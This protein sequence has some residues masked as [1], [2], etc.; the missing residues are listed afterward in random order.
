MGLAGGLNLYGF[1]GGD[2]VNFSDPFGLCPENMGGDG[3]HNTLG[4]CPVGSKGAEEFNRRAGGAIEKAP[5]SPL[6]ALE[7][8]ATAGVSGE[9]RAAIGGIISGFTK[10]GINQAISR[11]GVGVSSKAIL[12]AVKN[13]V[14]TVLQSEGRRLF[15]GRDARVVVNQ[16]GEVITAQPLG[17]RAFR[18][19]P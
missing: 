11:E 16:A 4:D 2:P 13:P 7:F 6:D 15:I 19:P 1:A 8:I 5:V 3:K 14:K 17:S 10:H 9:A 18:I 12:D